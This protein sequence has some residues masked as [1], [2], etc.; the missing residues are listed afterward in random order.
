[1]AVEQLSDAELMRI[2]RKGSSE[3]TT[4]RLLTIG[5]GRHA[6]DEAIGHRCQ[7]KKD[8]RRVNGSHG[9]VTADPPGREEP[10]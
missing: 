9:D 4:Q 8:K 5:P 3:N 10:F 7:V 2:V 6:R 1:M